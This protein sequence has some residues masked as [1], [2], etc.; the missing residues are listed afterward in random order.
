MQNTRLNSIANV[1][2]GRLWQWLTN[3]WRRVSLFL[4]SLSF[5]FVL[6]SIVITTAGATSIWDIV[7][8]VVAILTCELISI[9][10]YRTATQRQDFTEILPRRLIALEMLN[11][12]KIGFTFSLFL[13]AFKLGS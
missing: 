13:D 2:S 1:L 10:V 7:S 5:G 11:A 6:G 12:L 8:T 9:F 4:I 3:P